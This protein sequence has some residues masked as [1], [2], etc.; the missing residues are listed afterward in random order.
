[1]QY[2]ELR[3]GELGAPPRRQIG[4]PVPQP[5]RPPKFPS[6]TTEKPCTRCKLIKPL[7]EYSEQKTGA[8][9]RQ[10][11]CKACINAI[12]R[13]YTRTHREVKAGRQRPECCDCCGSQ[14]TGRRP[15]H[16]D[17]DHATG[18][19][20]GWLC[21]PCNAALG[22]VGDRVE[23]LDLLVTYLKRGGGMA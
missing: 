3:L 1:M 7:S 9:G 17:H 20:R 6:G 2:V 8:L 21:H 10:S 4:D 11:R 5:Y 18:L 22:H 15:M 23:R 19:F 13:E 12:G 14:R 16:W